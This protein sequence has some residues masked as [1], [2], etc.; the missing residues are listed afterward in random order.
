MGRRQIKI[1]LADRLLIVS[2]QREA[3]Y[4]YRCQETMSINKKN[5]TIPFIA[6]YP[7]KTVKKQ[8]CSN[9]KQLAF[10]FLIINL[11]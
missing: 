3:D 1:G 5:A 9:M 11:V 6:Y 7:N 4:Y 10:H 8:C 2:S